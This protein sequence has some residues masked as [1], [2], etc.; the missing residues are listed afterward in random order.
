[1]V[2]ELTRQASIDE[3]CPCKKYRSFALGYCV[4][5]LA[6]QPQRCTYTPGQGNGYDEER[7]TMAYAEEQLEGPSYLEFTQ[8]QVAAANLKSQ[9]QWQLPRQLALVGFACV[10]GGCVSFV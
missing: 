8:L 7:R 9:L 2:P 3:R 6:N 5:C 10:T 1:M 4:H